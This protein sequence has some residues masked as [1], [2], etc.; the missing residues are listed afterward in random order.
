MRERATSTMV[1][2]LMREVFTC[3]KQWKLLLKEGQIKDEK[4]DEK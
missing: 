1:M 2:D 3:W 4:H